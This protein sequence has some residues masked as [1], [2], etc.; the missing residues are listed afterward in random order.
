[1]AEPFDIE[2]RLAEIQTHEQPTA[3]EL[4]AAPVI[5]LWEIWSGPERLSLTATASPPTAPAHRFLL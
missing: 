1:M 5:D 2:A 4:D 3:A